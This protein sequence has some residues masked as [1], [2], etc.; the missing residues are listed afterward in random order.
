MAEGAFQ[1]L[2]AVDLLGAEAVRLEQGDF[3]RVSVRAQP[4]QLVRRFAAAG[5]RLIHVVD[6]DGARLGRIRADL[7]GRLAAA[8]GPAELQASGGIRSPADAERLLAAGAA[9]VVVG[10]AALAEAEALEQ[11]VAR[12]G[13]R[14]VVAID[15]RGGRVAARGWLDDTGLEAADVARRCAEAGV[16]RIL[17]TAIERDGMLGGP[18]L[19]LLREVRDASGLPVLAA[20]GIRSESDLAAV[21]AVG[22]EGAVVGRALLDGSLP[23]SAVVDRETPIAPTRTGSA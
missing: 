18:D 11:F 12:L 1:V 8:A 22:C 7:I 20:G 9:R 10:T 19:D 4:E 6:L 2:P 21:A 14:L 13:D 3:G 23:L 15:V 17:C 5:A 16:P